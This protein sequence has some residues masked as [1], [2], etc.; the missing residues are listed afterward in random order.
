MNGTSKTCYYGGC[1]TSVYGTQSWKRLY[2]MSYQISRSH[3]KS[4]KDQVGERASWKGKTKEERE[5]T[6][7]TSAIYLY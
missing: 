4:L 2:G 7:V 6:E 3:A 1:S 5:V